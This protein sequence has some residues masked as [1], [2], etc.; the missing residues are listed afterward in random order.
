MNEKELIIKA[1]NI[2]SLITSYSKDSAWAKEYRIIYDI[3][4]ASANEL[5]ET[6]GE[7]KFSWEEEMKKDTLTMINS[8]G[9]TKTCLRNSFAYYSYIE[10]GFEE[11]K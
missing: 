1:R 7:N 10:Q 9:E 2:V 8:E 11:V 5:N 4:Q 6:L 3:F